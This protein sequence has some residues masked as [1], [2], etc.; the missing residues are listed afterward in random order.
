[1]STSSLSTAGSKLPSLYGNTRL[2]TNSSFA[3][4]SR[5]SNSSMLS[6]DTQS[7]IS[8][9]KERHQF[10]SI[11][12]FLER[13][14]GSSTEVVH[15]LQR[16][17]RNYKAQIAA[18]IDEKAKILTASKREEAH[19]EALRQEN[20]ERER[21][22]QETL[23]CL[24]STK[25]GKRLDGKPPTIEQLRKLSDAIMKEGLRFKHLSEQ[26][27]RIEREILG[28]KLDGDETPFDIQQT[29][30][31]DDATIDKVMEFQ[32]NKLSNLVFKFEDT[33][34]RLNTIMTNRDM[35]TR[36]IFDRKTAL[37]ALKVK[38]MSLI[39]EGKKLEETFN[40]NLKD[41]ATTLGNLQWKNEM[42]KACGLI[43]ALPKTS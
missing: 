30:P 38:K 37:E 28:A 18:L 4:R 35:L 31:K 25:P 7:S 41:V 24:K 6:S 15:H 19:I 21:G 13:R 2:G 32:R 20:E 23:R 12:Y 34:A 40:K 14:H 17:H 26:P 3:S 9:Q 27:K 43:A 16:L 39:E 22:I 33:N 10:K 29:E 11:S 8:S 5:R 42:T 36:M 1:M